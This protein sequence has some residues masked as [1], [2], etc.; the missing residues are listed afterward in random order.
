MY[1]GYAMNGAVLGVAVGY[2]ALQAVLAV[3][4]SCA[5]SVSLALQA[6]RSVVLSLNVG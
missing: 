5:R 2:G 4:A 6:A 1:T 3:A